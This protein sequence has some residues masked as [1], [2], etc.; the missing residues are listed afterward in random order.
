MNNKSLSERLNNIWN[1]GP[2]KWLSRELSEDKPEIM[3]MNSPSGRPKPVRKPKEPETPDYETP[4]QAYYD[5][6][7]GGSGHATQRRALQDLGFRIDQRKRP[8]G[9]E[10]GP[11]YPEY[12][13]GGPE[14]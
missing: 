13:L 14:G 11:K 7:R 1:R 5:A 8:K 10:T 4:L 3:G 2:D 6:R 12:I 9:V